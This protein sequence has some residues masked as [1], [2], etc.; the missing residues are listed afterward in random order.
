MLD[1]E[2]I[3]IMTRCARYEKGQG[4][5]DLEVNKY[6]QGDY[7]RMN[8]LKSLIGVTVVFILC[9]GVYVILRAEYLLSNIVTMDIAAFGRNILIYYIIALIV[10]GAISVLFYGWKYA[11]TQKRIRWYYEDL[12]TL[13]KMNGVDTDETGDME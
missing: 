6:Y 8:T 2:K 4:K 7:I 11:D 10:F 9:F 3:R 5:K 12:K 13:D 1:K